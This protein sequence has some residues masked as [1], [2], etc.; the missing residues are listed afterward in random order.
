MS[1][2][3]PVDL[4]P[5]SKGQASVVAVDAGGGIKRAM[6]ASRQGKGAYPHRTYAYSV[7]RHVHVSRS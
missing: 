6:K 7:S 3:D 4:G 5:R 1:G 2:L